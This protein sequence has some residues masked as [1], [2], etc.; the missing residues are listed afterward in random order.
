MISV[1]IYK[2]RNDEYVCFSAKGH[3]GYAREGK[4]IV[5]SAVSMLIINTINSIETLTDCS[6]DSEADS[7]TGYIKVTFK[8]E[9]T[10]EAKLLLDAMV[11]GITQAI[12]EYGKSYVTLTI[13]EV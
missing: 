5:C 6:F 8:D 1:S 9:A 12:K 13:K 10:K 4:D 3:A 7:S 11:L 2:N